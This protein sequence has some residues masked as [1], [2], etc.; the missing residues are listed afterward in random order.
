[1]R[2]D[3]KA[4]IPLI[5]RVYPSVQSGGVACGSNSDV[6][7]GTLTWN[8]L[9]DKNDS[10]WASSN[11]TGQEYSVVCYGKYSEWAWLSQVP[12]GS[13]NRGLTNNKMYIYLG[14]LLQNA[15]AG[16]YSTTIYLDITHE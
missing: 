3:G 11:T 2:S 10:N 7:N 6:Y 4:R 9:L 12:P 8:Y 14:S 13:G 15:S 5:W 1:M 16:D